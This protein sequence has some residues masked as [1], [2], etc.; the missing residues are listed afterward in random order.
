M[1][2]T[3]K[4]FLKAH[5]A[6]MFA[7]LERVVCINSHTPNVEGVNK[8]AD[9][10][11]E[12]FREMGFTVRRMP[13]EFTGDNMVAE[14]RARARNGGG[15]L[16]VGHMD[17][18]YPPEMGFNTFRREGD[19]AFGPGVADMKGGLVAAIFAA[20]ALQEAGLKDIPVGL[21]FNADE[22]IG[23]PHSRDLIVN[24]AKRSVCC[25]VMEASGQGGQVVTGRKGRIVFDLKVGGHPSHAG[26][27]PF[28]K[29]SAIVEIAH[30]LTAMEALNDPAAGIT[31]NAGY[32]EGGVGPNTVAASAVARCETR[33]TCPEDGA[34]VW[35]AIRAIAETPTLADTSGSV[36]I[37]VQRPP[38]V[39]D[40]NVLGL[41][42]AIHEAADDVGLEVAQ[43]SLG[44]G[45]D[46]NTVAQAEIPVVDGMGP[47]GSRIHT[48]DEYMLTETMLSQTLLTAVSIIKA[49]EKYS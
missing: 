3:I 36:E 5:E 43:V 42:E 47:A 28:P 27:A 29:P 25:F 7:L 22:E 26:H 37:L 23:S 24:E 10:F 12:S 30:K 16:L 13:N 17:T 45:S 39:A 40:D 33:F 49:V 1:I 18:V 38:L 20:R 19:R 46:A 8:V 4:K 32:V 31:F 11:Q 6:E 21:F 48:P 34:K 35:S 44:G 9:V 2:P 41:Y 14:N 15:A